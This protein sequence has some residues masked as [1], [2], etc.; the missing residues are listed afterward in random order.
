MFFDDELGNGRIADDQASP[1]PC[2]VFSDAAH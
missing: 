1:R 2:P